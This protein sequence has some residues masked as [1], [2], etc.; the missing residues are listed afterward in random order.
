MLP[1]GWRP[2][3]CE[4][5]RVTRFPGVSDGWA[6]FDGPAGTQM[7]DV[8][9]EAAAAWS[10]SGRNANAHGEFPQADACDELLDTTR[11]SVARLLGAPD[12]QG[13]WF[14]A[15]MTTMTMAFTRGSCACCGRVIASSAPVSITMPT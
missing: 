15:N 12:P 10:R 7:V 4:T 9:I 14:G 1:V 13:I 8:A 6:R 11:A 2:V 3:N 5:V